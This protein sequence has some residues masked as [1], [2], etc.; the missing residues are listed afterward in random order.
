MTT[1]LA[2]PIFLAG[3]VV[4]AVAGFVGGFRFADWL[5]ERQQRDRSQGLGAKSEPVP[6]P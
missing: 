4:G 5:N 2:V 3:A 1:I 6:S